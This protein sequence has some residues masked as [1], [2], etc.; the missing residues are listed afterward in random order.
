M[1]RRLGKQTIEF[2]NKPK[3]IGNYSIVGEKEG[4][5]NLKDY[6]DYVLKSD[7]FGEKT[8]EHAER[9]IIEHAI[10]NSISSANL[11]INNIKRA[12]VLKWV[13]LALWWKEIK[14]EE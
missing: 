3:I 13:M 9:K 11:K 1:G 10:S 14:N 7:T 5:G 2:L 4:N 6:F 12:W 8:F